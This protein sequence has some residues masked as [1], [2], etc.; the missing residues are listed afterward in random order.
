[1]NRSTF[2]KEFNEN[3]L[4]NQ[5]PLS[6]GGNFHDDPLMRPNLRKSHTLAN[7]S[8]GANVPEGYAPHTSYNFRGDLFGSTQVDTRKEDMRRLNE[9]KH[10]ELLFLAYLREPVFESA[11]EQTRIRKLGITYYTQDGTI[12]INEARQQNSGISQG[13]FLAR[14]KVPRDGGAGATGNIDESDLVVG[15]TVMIYGR[16]FTI[17]GVNGATRKYLEEK[18]VPV[19]AENLP[20]PQDDTYNATIAKG[21]GT[22]PMRRIP[23]SDMENKRALESLTSGGQITKH[24]PED[25]RCTQQFYAN[26]IN[27]HLSFAALYDNRAKISGDL[28]HVVLNYYLENDTIE[29][30]EDRPENHGKDGGPKL[31]VRQRVPKPGVDTS[32]VRSQHNTF[33]VILKSD[34]MTATDLA[35]NETITIHARPY[36]I[37]DADE[38]TRNYFREHFNINLAPAVD[39]SAIE[40]KGAKNSPV[41]YPPPHNGFGTDI[42]SLQNCKGLTLKPPRVDIEK[43]WREMDKTMIFSAVLVTSDPVDSQRQFVVNFHRATDEVE[44]GEKNIRNSGVIGGKFLAKGR[45]LKEMPNGKKVAFS[46]E[47]FAEGKTV[48][49]CGRTF[50]LQKMDEK[51]RKVALGIEDDIAEDRVRELVLLFRTLVATKYLRVQEAFRAIAP[52]GTLTVTDMVDFFRRSSSRIRDEEAMHI[53]QHVAPS[54]NGTI[55]YDQFLRFVDGSEGTSSMDAASNNPKSIKNVNMQLKDEFKTATVV[56]TEDNQRRLLKKQLIDKLVARRGTVQEVFRLM[57]GH[58]FNSRLSRAQ[59]EKGLVDILHFNVSPRETELLL[60]IVF[61]GKEDS[62]GEITYKQFNEFVESA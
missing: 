5:L 17:T 61:D 44:I 32:K 19:P 30:V 1:M 41:H 46:P 60:S 3:P 45:H 4:H 22:N 8:C 6:F 52:S 58:S 47:D 2:K 25:I 51:S 23:T 10:P 27:Q 28:H 59:F 15:G 18:G 50:L 40:Q 62:N 43:Q 29:I 33:G 55:T 37:Y 34:Y 48:D 9:Y 56:A 26:K 24:H 54:G 39:I 38:F 11:V 21:L 57:A 36:F 42:D 20:W 13:Q 31:L 35:I 49:I 53:I 12:S 16:A 7:A 14:Q